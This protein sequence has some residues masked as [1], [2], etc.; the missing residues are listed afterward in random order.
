GKFAFSF[1]GSFAFFFLV[2]FAFPLAGL[3]AHARRYFAVGL[4]FSFFAGLFSGAGFVTGLLASGGSLVTF[5]FL[6]RLAILGEPPGFVFRLFDE[7]V[8][9]GAGEAKG[10]AFVSENLLG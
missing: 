8:E 7:S 3:L 9:L 10:V 2:T 1:A 4:A 5:V 6:V